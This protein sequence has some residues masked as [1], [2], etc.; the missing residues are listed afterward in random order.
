MLVGTRSLGRAGQPTAMDRSTLVHDLGVH[1]RLGPRTVAT[2]SYVNNISHN[3]NTADM[4]L[5]LRL[6]FLLTAPAQ[7]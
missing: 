1:C 2:F 3:E 5:A 7:G 4:G 6:A